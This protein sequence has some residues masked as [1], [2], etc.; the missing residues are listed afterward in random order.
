MN[1]V[2]NN[3]WGKTSDLLRKIGN[4][5]GIFH[6]KMGTIK[7][8]NVRDLIDAEEMERIH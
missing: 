5:K 4:I 8:R 1:S 3:R 7:E 2:E 6:P